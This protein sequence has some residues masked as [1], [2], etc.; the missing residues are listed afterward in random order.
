MNKKVYTVDDVTDM[1]ASSGMH[2]DYLIIAPNIELRSRE[3][4]KKYRSYGIFNKIVLMDYSN[5]H[6][7]ITQEQE[8]SFYVDFEQEYIRI[9]CE[10][11][12]AVRG[13]KKLDINENAKIAID[14]TG[15]SIPDIYQVLYFLKKKLYLRSVDV[16]YTE[17][18]FYVYDKGYYNSYHAYL[19]ERRCA[20]ISGYY[21]SGKNEEEVLTIFLGFDGGSADLV[22]LKLGEEAQEITDVVVVNGFPSYTPKLKDVSLLNNVDIITKIGKKENIYHASASNPFATYNL[23]CLLKEKYKNE[24]LNI[25]TI[26]SKPMALGA[27]LFAL[28]YSDEVKVTYP[29]YEKVNFDEDEKPGKIW[30]YI[31]EF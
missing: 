22:Y 23:L 6:K 20:P 13:L 1:D 24:L 21:N 25:C 18:K 26:G 11:D 2:Y 19:G 31:V 12:G 15:F 9:S 30:R 8:N 5:F 14:I 27:C 28:D 7:K 3:F 4:F 17:P 10:D 16:F 29:Y